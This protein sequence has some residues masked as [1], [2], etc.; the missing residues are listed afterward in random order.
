MSSNRTGIC[1]ALQR[2]QL[3]HR[4][5]LYFL[6]NSRTASSKK[7]NVT[8]GK[9]KCR[10]LLNYKAGLLYSLSRTWL[11]SIE[12]SSWK[13]AFLSSSLLTGIWS[14][15]LAVSSV[16]TTCKCVQCLSNTIHELYTTQVSSVLNFLSSLQAFLPSSQETW[17]Y[18][19]KLS[20][21]LLR[22][23]KD[24]SISHT[25]RSWETYGGS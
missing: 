22:P 25:R 14:G 18:W 17:I 3:I 8:S 7:L 10:I 24:R 21:K 1:M 6:Q 11:D 16:C 20:H 19:T 15:F 9:Y 23:L 5:Q 13:I 4:Y 2:C 12:F